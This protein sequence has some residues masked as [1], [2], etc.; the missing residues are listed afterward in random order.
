MKII[1]DAMGGDHAPLEIVKGALRAKN[2]LGVELLL[3]GR[4]E[5]I[6]EILAQENADQ[7]GID[8]IMDVDNRLDSEDRLFRSGFSEEAPDG[9]SYTG[10]YDQADE[11]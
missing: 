8:S 1:V 4:E 11:E 7:T 5:A 9:S 6:R 10:S 2:E 3:V